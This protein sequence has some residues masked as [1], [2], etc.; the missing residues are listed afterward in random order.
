MNIQGTGQINAATY[1]TILPQREKV[2]SS[3]MGATT[4]SS[5]KDS[6]QQSKVVDMHNI[7]PNEY[8]EL[9]RSGLAELPVP[10]VLPP[11]GRIY[12]DGDPTVL[13]NLKTDYIGQIENS[14]DFCQSICDH[15]MAEFYAGRLSIVKNLHGLEYSPTESAAGIDITA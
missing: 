12:L 8:A 10:M 3:Q 9:V 11:G 4:G 1:G 13:G 15:K 5:Q 7:S 14:M 6:V 2:E